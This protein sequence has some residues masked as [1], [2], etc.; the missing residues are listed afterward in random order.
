LAFAEDEEEIILVELPSKS[1]NAKSPDV[2]IFRPLQGEFEMEAKP[3]T[4]TEPVV[5]E[6]ESV[7]LS[8]FINRPLSDVL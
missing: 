6:G 5:M 3:K 2:F 8:D 4:V 7:K 1:P